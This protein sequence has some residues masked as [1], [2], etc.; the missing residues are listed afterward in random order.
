MTTA[1]YASILALFL[2]ILSLRVIA[3]R[4]NPLFRLLAFRHLGQ[5]TLDRAI[6]G[7]GNLTE[8]AP[9]M[10]ILMFLA[11][12][13]GLSATALHL[14]G[15]MFLVGRLAHGVCFGFMTQSMLLRIGGTALT[16]TAI[17]ALAIRLLVG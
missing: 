1:T 4:G 16:L 6:R 10:L 17:G 13:Q 2:V 7:H 9:I 8:Y 15:G 3:L 12:Q 11:E 14:L 5:A